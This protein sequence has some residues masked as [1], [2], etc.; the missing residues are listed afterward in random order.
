[1][2]K[3]LNWCERDGKVILGKIFKERSSLMTIWID[4]Q[5]KERSSFVKL[6]LC[7]V[8]GKFVISKI[9]KLVWR[10]W[11]GQHWW[12][13]ELMYRRY[14]RMSLVKNLNYVKWM[15]RSS[16]LK[17]LNW[18][19]EDGKVIISKIFKL[20]WRRWKGQHWWIDVQE[21]ERMSLVKKLKFS[22]VNGMV[23][24]A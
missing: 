22:E 10:R 12:I 7:E 21:M 2:E 13:F 15:E 19:E 20:V 6:S 18:N 16:W 14:K 5:E 9:F 3:Y 4:V 24:M 17:Y 8:D 1:M 23:V 11:K